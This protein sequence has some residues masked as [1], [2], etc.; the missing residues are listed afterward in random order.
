ML[1][2]SLGLIRQITCAAIIVLTGIFLSDAANAKVR[3]YKTDAN[4]VTFSLDKGLMSIKVCSPDIIQVRYTM[5][6]TFAA[7]LELVVNNPWIAKTPFK[8]SEANGIIT[9]TTS[10]LKISVDKA[11]NAITYYDKYGKEITSES[12]KNNKTME[13][14]TVA[15]ISTYTCSNEFNSP[16]DEALYGLGLPPNRYRFHK[17]QGPRP[18]LADKVYDRCHP[19]NVI[20]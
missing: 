3:S 15:G 14:A 7:K 18:K 2:K 16:S 12:K 20:E 17:L 6:D 10:K 19:G 13:A 11:S 1:N 5:F 9:I 4:G 8:V